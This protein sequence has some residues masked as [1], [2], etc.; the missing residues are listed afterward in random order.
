MVS[1]GSV[2]AKNWGRGFVRY[3]PR[4]APSSGLTATFSPEGEKGIG[5]STGVPA[6]AE[7]EDGIGDSTGV[8]AFAEAHLSHPTDN[9]GLCGV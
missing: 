7:G 3:L 5:G 9:A 4:Y 6:F 1:H 2:L 8:P